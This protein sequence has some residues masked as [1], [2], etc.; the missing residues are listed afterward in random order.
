MTPAERRFEAL[1]AA[2]GPRVL[3]YLTRRTTPVED[4]ADVYQEALT[5]AWRKVHDAPGDPDH[6]IAWLL[7]IARRTLANHRRSRTRRLAATQR[8]VDEL[9]AGHGIRD[10]GRASTDAPGGGDG[11]DHVHE[12]LAALAPD[13]REVLTLTYWD[14]LTCAQVAVVVG[15]RSATARKRL[16]RARRRVAAELARG[17][18]EPTATGASGRAGGTHERPGGGRVGAVV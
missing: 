12:A 1:V 9:A 11:L 18:G 4:A 2:H 13:D 10:V 6:A 8:L 3:A 7:A 14:G 15:V 16:E 5:T 17:D